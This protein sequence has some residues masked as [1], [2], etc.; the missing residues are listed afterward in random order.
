MYCDSNKLRDYGARGAP[1]LVVEVLSPYTSK[2]DL[3]DKFR[4]YE[5][6]R[7]AEYWV[8]DPSGSI[9]KSPVGPYACLCALL[10]C[11]III[12]YCMC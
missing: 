1:D 11:S 10:L 9:D 4:L 3:N 8:V 6:H 2:K 5:Y 12:V 7:V